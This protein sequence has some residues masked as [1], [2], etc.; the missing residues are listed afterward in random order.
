VQAI[1]HSCDVFFYTVAD[2]MGDLVLNKFA[3]DFGVGRKTGI[4]LANE[5]KGIAPDRDWKK[6]YF[7][8]AYKETGDAAWQ[9]STWYEGNTVTYGIG[10][11]FL[12]TTPLQDLMWTSTVANGGSYMRPQ[13]TNRVTAAQDGKVVHPFTPVKDHTVGVDPRYLAII[14]DG[15][16]AAAD[17]GG[18]SGFIWQQA[19]FKNVPSPSG[20]T[21]TAQYGVPDAKGNYATHAWYTAYA[22]A[23]DPEVAVVVF[24]EGGGEGHQAAA[25]V[26]AQILSYYFAHRDA[27]RAQ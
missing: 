1:A 13:L 15:L 12:L 14:R 9:E 6:A 22:P 2:R 8:E 26:A 17:R 27:I 7:A 18:T 4:D 21:G 5:A 19:A 23:V 10:Q 11:S 3:K 16:L 20:K 24:V 25:P